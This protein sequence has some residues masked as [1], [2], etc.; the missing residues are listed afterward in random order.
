MILSRGWFMR[1]RSLF[2]PVVLGTLSFSLASCESPEEKVARVAKE[3]AAAAARAE[4]EKSIIVAQSGVD[5]ILSQL[6]DPGS[7][8]FQDVTVRKDSTVCGKVNSK[9]KF[10]GYV[11][12]QDFPSSLEGTLI[13]EDVPSPSNGIGD[14]FDYEGYARSSASM[15][16]DSGIM[17]LCP[18]STD[19]I[20]V[21]IQ[22]Q[23]AV[24]SG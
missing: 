24:P 19:S 9:N 4:N 3:N 14:N 7:A 1:C 18:F 17:K 16:I 13:H 8:T 2:F 23:K 11:G 6:N 20:A 10:G 5:R 22:G 21:T 12:F 15:T